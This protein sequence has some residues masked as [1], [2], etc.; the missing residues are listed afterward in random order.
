M[1]LWQDC[2]G[3]ST[4]KG[5]R[6]SV[7]IPANAGAYSTLSSRGQSKRERLALKWSA[8]FFVFVPGLGFASVG[9]GNGNGLQ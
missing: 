3:A 6:G 9:G 4:S 2:R 5:F 1:E 8:N 7:E